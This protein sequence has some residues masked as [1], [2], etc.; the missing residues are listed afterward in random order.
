L[1]ACAFDCVKLLFQ[2]TKPAKCDK[3]KQHI[4]SPEKRKKKNEQKKKKRYAG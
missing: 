3:Q 2:G 1:V 4:F